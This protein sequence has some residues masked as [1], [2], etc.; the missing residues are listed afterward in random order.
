M[1]LEMVYSLAKYGAPLFNDIRLRILNPTTQKPVSHSETLKRHFKEEIEIGTA[2][3]NVLLSKVGFQ[4][5]VGQPAEYDDDGVLI[6]QGVAP[7]AAIYNMLAKHRLGYGSGTKNV[8]V[9]HSV[10]VDHE[11]AK[12]LSELSED[13]LRSIRAIAA[14][15]ADQKTEGAA[16]GDR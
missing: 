12:A 14:K 16:E 2:D 3:G 8:S 13:E 15:R 10:G 6:R 1:R 5:A 7:N 4:A 11:T 9:V